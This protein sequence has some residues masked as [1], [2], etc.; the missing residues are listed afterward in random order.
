MKYPFL[1]QYFSSN[2]QVVFRQKAEKPSL[3]YYVPTAEEETDS[4]VSLTP[5]FELCSSPLPHDNNRYT[6]CLWHASIKI[7]ELW[8][9]YLKYRKFN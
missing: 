8:R 2:R 1:I 4:Y 5:V 9:T 3:P 6:K 7:E